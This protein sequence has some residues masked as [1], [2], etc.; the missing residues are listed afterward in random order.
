[1]DGIAAEDARPLSDGYHAT[2]ALPGCGLTAPVAWAGEAPQAMQAELDF[3]V[4]AAAHGMPVLAPAD[5]QATPT[6]H[7][8]D[9]RFR[10]EVADAVALPLG[11]S[12]V[13]LAFSTFSHHHWSD[14]QAGVREIARV[15]RPAGSSSLPMSGRRC[16]LEPTRTPGKGSS[17]TPA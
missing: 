6:G 2:I 11:A 13:D 9:A 15:L 3:A 5:P 12:A 10:F 14:Q 8:S 1:M 16:S 4:L 17:R 7:G